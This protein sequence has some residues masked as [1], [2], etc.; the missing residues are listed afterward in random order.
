MHLV[1]DLLPKLLVRL[2]GPRTNMRHILDA[3]QLLHLRVGQHFGLLD[4]PTS[5]GPPDLPGGRRGRLDGSV[6]RIL[7]AVHIYLKIYY[8]RVLPLYSIILSCVLLTEY[9]N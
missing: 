8:N 1:R 9:L 7:L 4:G 3:L 2:M 5:L 6:S